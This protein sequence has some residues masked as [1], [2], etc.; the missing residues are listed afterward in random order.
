MKESYLKHLT[1]A[2]IGTGCIMIALFSVDPVLQSNAMI[3]L[4]G[5]VG[6]VFKNGTGV[7][8]DAA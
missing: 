6:Y 4:A 8:V 2:V 3:M 7:K 1:I 5:I